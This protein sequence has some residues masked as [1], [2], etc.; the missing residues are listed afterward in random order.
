MELVDVAR[1]MLVSD[2]AI[3]ES[4][5]TGE[6]IEYSLNHQNSSILLPGSGSILSVRKPDERRVREIIKESGFEKDLLPE[7]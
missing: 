4:I 1:F 3:L 2:A 5:L 7:R 6:N